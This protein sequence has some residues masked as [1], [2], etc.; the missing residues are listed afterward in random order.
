MHPKTQARRGALQALVALENS[1]VPLASALND[2]HLPAEA[3]GFARE[4]VSGVCRTRSRLDHTLKPLLKKPLPKLDPPVRAALRLAT[5][6]RCVLNTPHSAIVDQYA[7]AMRAAHL[8]SAVGFVNAV[9]RRL[10]PKFIAS[11][12]AEK[13]AVAFLSVEYSHPVWIVA[14]WLKRLGIEACTALCQSNNTVA[15]LH[16]RANS[17]KTTRDRVLDS[18]RAR[19]LDA[20]PGA[21]S[22]DA[23]VVERGDAALGS[24]QHWP[25]WQ[26]GWILAQDEAAQCV[27]RLADPS[28]GDSVVDAC[29]APGGKSTHLAQMMKDKGTVLACDLAPGRLKLVRENAQHLGLECVE[30]RSGDFLELSRQLPHVDLVLL[31]HPV[32][33][34]ARGD[35]GLMHAGERLSSNLLNWWLCSERCWKPHLTW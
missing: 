2:L 14:R 17:M 35:A 28:E 11:P 7:E 32:W 29:A 23:I 34:Q 21:L 31:M 33:E 18:L 8:R 4:L 15:P 19:G 10:P 6:E 13:D 27:G 22:L 1:D 16:L 12:D 20:R 26:N 3:Q 24:P 5:Y 9:A 30:T 25:E